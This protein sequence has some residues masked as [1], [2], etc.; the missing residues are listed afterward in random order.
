TRLQE[1]GYIRYE[2]L[3]LETKDGR[4]INVEFVCNSYSV[5]NTKVIQCNIRDITDRRR[6]E[7]ALKLYVEHLK[8]SNE[9]LERF[10]YVASH[11][12]QEPLRTITNFSQLLARRYK[13]K[14]NPDADEYIEYIVDGGK[15]MQALVSDLL[16]YSRVNRKD[17]AF[18]SI[19]TNDLVD[20][21]IQNLYTRLQENTAVIVTE[22]L[23]PVRAD[24]GQLGLVFQNLIE[25]AIK[26]RRE[27]R[28]RVH[29]SAVREKG[30][31]RFTVADNGIGID[32]AYNERIFEIFQRLH[33]SDKYPGTGLGLAIVKRI[34]ERYGGKVW[35]ESVIGKGSTFYFTLPAD[36]PASPL[37]DA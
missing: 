33:T 7:E 10:A 1:E 13:G 16:D 24:P 15:R 6:I 2:D 21:I 25:N 37:P 30:M 22:P 14:L 23:P 26:F 34:I 18:L 5:N 36:D 20:D 9:D 17:S 8:Q 12:L 28:P 32:P 31:W 11:D 3:P 35:V 29:I 4:L 27:E 19:D